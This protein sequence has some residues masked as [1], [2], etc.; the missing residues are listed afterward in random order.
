METKH[1]KIAVEVC[2]VVL[3][4]VF[5]FSGFV[6]A[7][8][9]WGSAYKILD[10]YL[11]F[12]LTVFNFS[13]LPLSFLQSIVEFG[14]GA[15]LLIGVYRR[16]NSIFALLIM[17]FMTPLTLYIAIKNPVTDCGCFGD[18]LVISNWHTFYKNIFLLIA[19]VVVF[20][21]YR[22]MTPCFTRKG[23]SLSA[24]WIY[25]F[26]TGVS[27]YCFHYLPVFDFRPYKI[28]VNIYE[29]MQMPEGAEHDVYEITLIYSKDGEEKE[30]TID[31]YP[32]GD[33]SWAF[34]DS[35]NR[36]V[37]KGYQPPIQGFSFTNAH[38]N[39]ITDIILSDPSYTFLL[40]AYQLDKANDANVDKI[41][42]IY[43]FSRNRGYEFY[44]LTSS[45][46]Q[47]THNWIENT[48]AEYP[49]C[50]ADEIMLKTIVRSNPGLLLLKG[51]TIINKWPN[52]RLPD[53]DQLAV[54]LNETDE[55]KLP[56]VH[57][58]WTLF[59]LALFLFIPLTGI[60][61][62]DFFGSRKEL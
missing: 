7:V 49:F 10:Y 34:V 51:G 16:I 24:L 38:G 13:A 52:T 28:G 15:C 22:L 27:L 32:Q 5:V 37:K 8:D 46:S 20:I 1:K 2:R 36:L 6:K 59:F 53:I 55:G 21:C 44:A 48:G 29:S 23:Y 57:N 31:N 35:R 12:N 50:T 54:L 62:L 47:S 41:N 25:L 17:L 19:A 43:D 11:A 61:L 26:I 30:F 40:I 60:F 9:P 33:D 45:S 58:F 4:L 39:D 14:V 18:A 42:D 3:G 56:A